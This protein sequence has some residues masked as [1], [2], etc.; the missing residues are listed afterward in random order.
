ME[1]ITQFVKAIQSF[2]WDYL[3]IFLLCGVGLFFTI[4][5][6]GVQIRRFIPGLR[7]MFSGFSLKG[8]KAGKHGMSSFQAVTTAIAG[9]VG[10]GNLAGAATA[11]V[12]GGPGAIFW[13][14]VSAFLGMA[15][16]YA[17]ALLA[18]RF[19]SRDESGQ[20]VGGPAYYIEKGLHCKWLARLF[21]ALLIL[22][23]GFTGNMVQSNS[24]CAAF[25]T[26]LGL[27]RF[28][29]G[30]AVAALAAVILLGGI[31]RIAAFTEKVVPVMA[32]LYLVGSVAV[33]AVHA[34]RILPA[35]GM[36]FEAAFRPSAA[37][38][39]VAGYTVLRSMKY[40]VARGL[41]SNEAGMG[42][43]PHAHAVAKVDRPEK[44]GHV[45][46]VSVFFDTFVVLTLTALV[47]LTS[48]VL[49]GMIRED[50]GINVT[51]AAFSSSMGAFGAPFIAFCLLFFAFSTII[52]WYYYGETNVRYLFRSKRAVPV[53]KGLVVGFVFLGS[54]FK[55]GL[56]WALSD[57]CNGL[58]VLPN[59]AALLLLFPTV[60]AMSREDR[61]HPLRGY[62]RERAAAEEKDAG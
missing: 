60:L 47:I 9:Q 7:E 20:A 48:G 38:G 50:A 26:S 53:Y 40:G 21:S 2:L 18:Q 36:I 34:D 49:P 43:T 10:T 55:S 3:L 31:G 44:Q 19:R 62:A 28:I 29:G 51:Q 52:S 27:P 8:A 4:A 39:G 56:V 33:L 22:A 37:F 13:M 24:I 35:F 41:F 45:A 5:L 57:V 59:L 54:L 23:L 11:I 25:E 32:C 12:L 46:I 58:M 42:S 15:T 17:E 61:S 16:I 1:G 14:W 30:L 6:K